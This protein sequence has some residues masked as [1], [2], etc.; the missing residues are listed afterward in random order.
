M[1]L[2]AKNQFLYFFVNEFY[3][4][5]RILNCKRAFDESPVPF[6]RYFMSR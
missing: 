4:W 6:A 2:P 5:R 3:L 1:D